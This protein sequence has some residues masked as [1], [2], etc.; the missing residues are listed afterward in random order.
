MSPTPHSFTARS[1]EDKFSTDGIPVVAIV[2]P[3][4]I[5]S[6]LIGSALL[7]WLAHTTRFDHDEANDQVVNVVLQASEEAH[8]EKS[9][10]HSAT[11]EKVNQE[12]VKS[13][14]LLGRLEQYPG[15]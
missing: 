4:V 8:D 15:Y 6:F 13:P 11:L 14:S 5:G 1:P 2:A 3:I 7:Y 12:A 9:H 10:T